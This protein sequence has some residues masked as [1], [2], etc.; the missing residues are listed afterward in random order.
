MDIDFDFSSKKKIK[1]K[2]IQGRDEEWNQGNIFE[3]RGQYLWNCAS[4][5]KGTFWMN[6]F[7]TF[8]IGN[9]AHKEIFEL[10]LMFLSLTYCI[11]GGWQILSSFRTFIQLQKKFEGWVFQFRLYC[12]NFSDKNNFFTLL[13]HKCILRHYTHHQIFKNNVLFL[14][15]DIWLVPYLISTLFIIMIQFQ[16]N[17]ILY[18]PG[19]TNIQFFLRIFDFFQGKGDMES[20]WIFEMD[21]EED[22][23]YF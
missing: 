6:L 14:Q 16:M 20:F 15:K 4:I 22:W 7:E 12:P 19:N 23:D 18:L 11:L 1:Y 10:S 9:V 3:W 21:D 17:I 2:S 5:F 8:V 13:H